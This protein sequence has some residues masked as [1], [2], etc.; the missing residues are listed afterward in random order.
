MPSFFNPKLRGDIILFLN[1]ILSI[2][3][4]SG[5]NKKSEVFFNKTIENLNEFD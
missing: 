2:N 3:D 5:F 1:K 4:R